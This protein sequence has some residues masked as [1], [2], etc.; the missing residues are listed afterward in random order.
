MTDPKIVQLHILLIPTCMVSSFFFFFF[1][2]PPVLF[3]RPRQ[4]TFVLVWVGGLSLGV[5]GIRDV[6]KTSSRGPSM[7]RSRYYDMAQ[8][9]G[10]PFLS[11][12]FVP[13][14]TWDR[15]DR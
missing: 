15:E 9:V 14:M 6:G 2:F 11:A 3:L 13:Q 5:T 8:A 7:K 10:L 12:D 4:T 1:F